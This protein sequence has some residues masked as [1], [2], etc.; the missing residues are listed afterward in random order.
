MQLWPKNLKKKKRLTKAFPR[1]PKKPRT[2]SLKPKELG[3]NDTPLII[4]YNTAFHLKKTFLLLAI[5]FL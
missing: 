3:T 5:R 2:L 1:Y 4:M